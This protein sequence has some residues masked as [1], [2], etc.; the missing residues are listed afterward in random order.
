MKTLAEKDTPEE[1]NVYGE[2]T[3]H[4]RRVTGI[5]EDEA[6]TFAV[7][8]R[9]KNIRKRQFVVQPDFPVLHRYYVKKGALRSYVVT[10][11]GQEHTIAFAIEDWWITDYNAYLY[12]QNATMFVTALE[13]SVV[14]QL[15]YEGEQKLKDLNPS[16]DRFFRIAAERGLA[17]QQRRVIAN[18]TLSA[19]QR[20]LQFVRQYP[21]LVQRVPQYALASFLGMTTEY[22]SKLRKK[23]VSADK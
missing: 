23:A 15:D 22:L 18:L 20:Y 5:E 13:D 12:R 16:F 19:E 17:Y 10:E 11:D 14:M 7:M 9:E 3:G 8:F 21:A 2:L 1:E 6:R 4:I